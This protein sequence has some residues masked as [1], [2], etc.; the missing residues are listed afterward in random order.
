MIESLLHQEET[1]RYYFRAKVDL[2]KG[3]LDK[4]LAF[5]DTLLEVNNK[6][7]QRSHLGRTQRFVETSSLNVNRNLHKVVYTK[8]E[9]YIAELDDVC[10]RL[11]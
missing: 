10:S 1:D 3:L 11:A 9:K 8:L 7:Q 4:Q 5:N 2:A 6:I